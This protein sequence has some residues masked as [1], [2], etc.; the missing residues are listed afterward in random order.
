MFDASVLLVEDDADV[1][2]AVLG[3]LERAGI[4]VVHA[5]TLAQAR[6]LMDEAQLV[7]LDRRLPDGDGLTLVRE[8]RAHQNPCGVLVLTGVD[9]VEDRVE[10]LRAGAD[11]YL[12]KPFH[13]AEL[14]A[15][16][17]ALGRRTQGH[18]PPTCVADLRYEPSRGQFFRAEDEL[19]LTAQEHRLLRYLLAN[20]GRVVP[21]EE[22]L[23][24]VWHIHHDPGTNVVEVYIRYLRRKVD[25]PYDPPLIHTVRGHGYVLE[26][27]TS[28]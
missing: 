25:V 24:E 18:A 28:P 14:L 11:D 19:V 12:A 13:G 17:Q 6:T 8:L 22:L 1:A 3:V 27:R 26:E 23:E 5:S 21:R 7:V 2:R 15:R 16:V 20:A 9:G 10:G 4:R